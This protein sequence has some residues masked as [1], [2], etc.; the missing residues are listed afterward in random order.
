MR[1]PP[2]KPL[3]SVIKSYLTHPKL[4][5]RFEKALK[6]PRNDM[7]DAVCDPGEYDKGIF[8]SV[9][10][11]HMKELNSETRAYEKY[12]SSTS[13]PSFNRNDAA[14]LTTMCLGASTR[15]VKEKLL[16]RSIVFSQGS[17]EVFHVDE[18]GLTKRHF[19]DPRTGTCDAAGVF[20]VP[21]F[22]EGITGA[23]DLKAMAE[24]H[25]F[26]IMAVPTP[27]SKTG[28]GPAEIS[29]RAQGVSL[30]GPADIEKVRDIFATGR[31]VSLCS[32][33]G[34]SP[35]QLHVRLP[36]NSMSG[37]T[38]ITHSQKSTRTPAIATAGRPSFEP[39]LEAVVGSLSLSDDDRPRTC[40]HL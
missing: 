17:S 18:K 13:T 33:E 34:M 31:H 7:Y 14:T 1:L 29:E 5:S 20:K 9:H 24:L 21:G 27:E 28:F 16:D 2:C 19:Q 38:N 36:L 37:K 8:G 22:F 40:H 39:A 32:E 4:C 10:S 35:F 25:R 30:N 15:H 3:E 6:M 11:T 12:A 23:R 26:S